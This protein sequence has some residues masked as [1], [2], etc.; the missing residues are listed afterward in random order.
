MKKKNNFLLFVYI[1]AII[2]IFNLILLSTLYYISFDFNYYKNK[3][4]KYSIYDKINGDVDN[5]FKEVLDYVKGDKVF[6]SSDLFNER[7][8]EHLK[9]VK[10]LF[11]FAKI[12]IVF[13][14]FLIIFCIAILEKKHILKA[15]KNASY[16]ILSFISIIS[17]SILINFEKAFIIFHEILFTNDLW[18]L[19]PRTDNLLKMMPEELFISLGIKWII[20]CLVICFILLMFVYNNK[21]ISFFLVLRRRIF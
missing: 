10:E 14:A 12:L 2:S 5:S 4:E 13:Y 11:Y 17:L 20:L 7:E 16:F 18:I 9:D 6:I 8:L 15:I 19:N 21:I 1:I 3:F